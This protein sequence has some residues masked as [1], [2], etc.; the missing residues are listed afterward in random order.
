[1]KTAL[2]LV[3]FC[4]SLCVTLA[5]FANCTAGNAIVNVK[6]P[7]T[8]SPT[9]YQLIMQN[10]SKILLGFKAGPNSHLY[11]LHGK[12][13]YHESDQPQYEADFKA[14]HAPN[15]HDLKDIYGTVCSQSGSLTSFKNC[16]MI[17][18]NNKAFDNSSYLILNCDVCPQGQSCS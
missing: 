15:I 8:F 16:K 18:I 10:N 7:V 5:S 9:E 13:K 4:L 2:R 11:K 3:C 1:M 6:F 12:T 14:G 17:F